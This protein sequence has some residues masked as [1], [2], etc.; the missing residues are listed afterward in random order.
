MRACEKVGIPRNMDFNAESTLGAGRIQTFVDGEECVRSNTEKAFLTPEIKARTNLTILTSAKCLRVIV[1]NGKCTGAIILHK[2]QEI[3]IH[4]RGQVILSC[5]AFDSPRVLSASGIT[6]PGIGKNLQD[7]LGINLSFRLPPQAPSD[8][9][10]ID[11]WNG[12]LNKFVTLYKYFM[13]RTGPA[14]SNLG[15]SVAFYRTSLKNVLESDKAAGEDAPH[16]ELIFVP[17]L[18]Q[19][20]EGQQSLVRIRPDFDWTRFEF[21]G[22]YI[23]IVPLLLNPYSV[24]ELRFKDG[25]MEIDPAYLRDKRDVDVLIEGVRM[26]RRIVREGFKEV[27]LEEMEEVIP[28]EYIDSDSQIESFIRSNAETYYHPVG[29]CKVFLSPLSLALFHQSPGI[30]SYDV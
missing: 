27:G 14:A 7:H 3:S 9:T 28:G 23:T 11:Q 2:G 13:Y 1:D 8:L 24:G 26:V 21:R 18:T 5:G 6:L 30:L 15:E 17:G 10:T 22:R 20:H 25:G 4:A 29:T 16:V 19:H 12:F